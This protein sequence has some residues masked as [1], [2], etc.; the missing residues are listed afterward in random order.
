MARKILYFINGPVPTDEERKEAEALD[1]VFRNANAAG[2]NDF[3]ENCDGVAGAVPDAYKE[4]FSHLGGAAN[5]NP[6]DID[7]M[8]TKQLQE[9][10]QQQDIAL[11][12]GLK[13]KGDIAAHIKAALAERDAEKE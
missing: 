4:K 13:A 10:A 9:Y 3:L 11:P 8:T 1:A 6:V 5:A 12:P 2:D 7:G